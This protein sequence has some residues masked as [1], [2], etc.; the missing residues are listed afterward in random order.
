MA[1]SLQTMVKIDDNR[2]QYRVSVG[3]RG[4][5][6]ID[7]KGLDSKITIQAFFN[8]NQGANGFNTTE[9]PNV[10]RNRLELEETD[11]EL[12]DEEPQRKRR[13]APRG[14]CNAAIAQETV[15][16]SDENVSVTNSNTLASVSQEDEEASKEPANPDG[17]TMDTVDSDE[18][19]ELPGASLIS[20]PTLED[21]ETMS[22]AKKLADTFQDQT[23]D[24]NVA[25]IGATEESAEPPSPNESNIGVAAVSEDNDDKCPYNLDPS[26]VTKDYLINICKRHKIKGRANKNK[27]QLAIHI[28]ENWQNRR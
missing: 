22:V 27:A 9:R 28:K 4:V 19:L 20:K 8:T 10:V 25:D 21:K 24:S 3:P 13:K 11:E 1:S 16:V 17:N 7:T 12:T 15:E 14:R 5:T 23:E 2:G 18:D 26:K 6:E